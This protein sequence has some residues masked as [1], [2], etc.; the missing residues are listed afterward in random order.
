MLLN[1]PIATRLPGSARLDHI[2]RTLATGLLLLAAMSALSTG[3]HLR[4]TEL[5]AERGPATSPAESIA[6]WYAQLADRD[7]DVREQARINLL[8]IRRDDL[9]HLEKIVAHS[10][11]IQ[12][13]Q[14]AVLRDIVLH[15]YIAGEA[16]EVAETWGSFLG[17]RDLQTSESPA[18]VRVNQRIIGFAA[19][20]A[21]REGD[22]IVGIAEMPDMPLERVE[23]LTSLLR[24]VPPGRPLTFMVFRGG[25]IQK[26]V[27]RPDPRPSAAIPANEQRMAE[28]ENL[29]LEKGEQYWD[30]TFAKLVAEQNVSISR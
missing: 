20:R 16:Y 7:P 17:L 11:P 10:S 28:M 13:S 19:Y 24:N 27:V 26:I 18:G 8:G 30:R 5:V 1:F 12:A 25:N 3:P 4:A 2:S 21:F 23:Q 15:V 9:P 6:N 29:R 14:A 22:V